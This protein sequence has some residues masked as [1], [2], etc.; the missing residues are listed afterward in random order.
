MDA[1]IKFAGELESQRNAIKT[2]QM[3]ALHE[4]R[5]RRAALNK[6][7]TKLAW[8]QKSAVKGS[9]VAKEL[10]RRMI[11]VASQIDSLPGYI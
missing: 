6:E 11:N 9:K 4:I 5:V 7:M 2:A 1:K 10:D 3:G 8:K